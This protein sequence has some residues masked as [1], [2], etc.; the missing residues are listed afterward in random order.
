MAQAS[1]NITVAGVQAERFQS[2]I[3]LYLASI[4]A[5]DGPPVLHP[6]HVMPVPYDFP[7]RVAKKSIRCVPHAQSSTPDDCESC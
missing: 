7:Q 5:M 3:E 2:L 4:P 1:T 6:L